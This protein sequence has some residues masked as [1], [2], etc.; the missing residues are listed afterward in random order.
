MPVLPTTLCQKL[1]SLDEIEKCLKTFLTPKKMASMV[2]NLKG[3]FL[4]GKFSRKQKVLILSVPYNLDSVKSTQHFFGK[5]D[6]MSFHVIA[7]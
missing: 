1:K 2:K 7:S 6:Y 4:Q 5:D 3:K